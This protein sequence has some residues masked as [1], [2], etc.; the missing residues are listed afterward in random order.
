ML[1]IHVEMMH[2][3][4]QHENKIENNLKNIYYNK[5]HKLKKT[6]IE[7]WILLKIYKSA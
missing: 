2:F 7:M 1:F 6:S 3:R 5:H 4:N